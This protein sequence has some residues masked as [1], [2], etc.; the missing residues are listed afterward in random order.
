MSLGPVYLLSPLTAYPFI[1][2]FFLRRDMVDQ[3]AMDTDVHW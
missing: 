3:S 2:A 1:I